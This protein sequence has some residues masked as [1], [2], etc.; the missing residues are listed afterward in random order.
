MDPGA[1]KIFTDRDVPRLRYIA[2]ILFGDLMGIDWEITTDKRKLGK[3]PVINYSGENVKGAFR[4]PKASL[5]FEDGVHVQEITISQWKDLPVFF[6]GDQG[7]DLPFDIF[8]AAFYL[9]SRYEEYLPFEPDQYGRF[10]AYSSLAWKNG[11]L[12][13]PVVDLWAKEW[14]RLLVMKFQN[15][16][17][18]K[19]NFRAMVSLD[20]DQPFEYLGKDVFR[21]LGGLIKDIGKK[22]GKPAERYRIVTRGEK[23]PWDVF[24]YIFSAVEESGNEARFF[25]P[26]GERSKYDHNPSWNNDEYRKLIR[27]VASRFTCGLHPSFAAAE[28]KTKLVE[29]KERLEKILGSRITLSRFHFLN[30][31]FPVS[32]SNMASAGFT[33]DYTMGY[34]DE[35]GFR[36]GLARPFYYYNLEAE[37]A[38]KLK[39]FPFQLMDATLYKY[40]SLSPEGA[41]EVVSALIEETRNVGGLF[42]TIWHNTS[43]L[44]NGEWHGWRGLFES[45]LK[46]QMQ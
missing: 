2:G 12:T 34:A 35:P 21:N 17:F 30:L 46:H 44:E 27:K 10:S 18:R 4:V 20:I 32:Y 8:A 36:A 15:M 23:D 40:K 9:V 43:L 22:A 7:G 5:I 33:E 39:V 26:T 37:K 3:H 42:I 29:E 41:G 16:V 11:F 14:T 19:N 28:N 31:K 13:R 45:M 25:I 38:T 6:Q 24:D 1:L